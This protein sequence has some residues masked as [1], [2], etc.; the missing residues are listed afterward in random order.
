Q[1]PA[2]RHGELEIL[3]PDNGKIL[4]FLRLLDEEKVLVV[5]NLSRFHQW[6]ELN[7]E[8]FDG[9]TP[10]EMAGGVRFPS[11]NKDPYRLSLSPFGFMWFSLEPSQDSTLEEATLPKLSVK[12]EWDEV[13]A[14]GARRKLERALS[15]WAQSRR[16]YRGKARRRTVATI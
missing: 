5:A 15:T 7:L 14:S 13:F 2:L 9:Y 4:A 1:H 8:R 6:L 16:W 11:I 3:S 12:R 10:V